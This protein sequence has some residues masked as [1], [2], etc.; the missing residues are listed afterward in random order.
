M[1][2]LGRLGEKDVPNR[3]AHINA[4]RREALVGSE[5]VG[6]RDGRRE[7]DRAH[8]KTLRWIQPASEGAQMRR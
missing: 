5:E 3:E 2:F 6:C 4:G 1:T 7:A 8:D